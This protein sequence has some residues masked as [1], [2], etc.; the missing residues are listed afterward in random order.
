MKQLERLVERAQENA[1]RELDVWEEHLGFGM[2]ADA[3]LL[4][5]FDVDVSI[6]SRAPEVIEPRVEQHNSASLAQFGA[7]LSRVERPPVLATGSAS[8]G[9]AAR[10]PSRPEC[11][12]L[13][14]FVYDDSFVWPRHFSCE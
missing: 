14:N 2:K 4:D 10:P 13:Y 12:S 1:G 6:A 7:S 3:V 8:T 5:L 11:L 9:P